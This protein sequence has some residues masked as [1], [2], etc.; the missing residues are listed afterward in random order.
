MP[1]YSHSIPL[2]AIAFIVWIIYETAAHR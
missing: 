2:G 1:R